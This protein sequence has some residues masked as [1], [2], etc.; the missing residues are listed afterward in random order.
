MSILY[1]VLVGLSIILGIVLIAVLNGNK[2]SLESK[3]NALLL[4]IIGNVSHGLDKLDTGLESIM[5][6]TKVAKERIHQ[7][8]ALHREN[9]VACAAARLRN[10]KRLDSLSNP[11]SKL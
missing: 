2:M 11:S 4:E 1:K 7:L 9:L 10:N 8:V 6:E 5:S 3:K